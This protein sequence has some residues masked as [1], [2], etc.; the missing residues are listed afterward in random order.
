MS[1]LARYLTRQLLASIGLALAVLLLLFGFFDLIDELGDLRPGTYT[2]GKAL[3]YVALHLPA[4][5]HE[6]MPIAAVIGALFAFARLADSSEFTVMRASG[7]S[8]LRLAR[9]MVVLGAGIAAAILVIGEYLTPVSERAAQQLKLRTTTSVVA[10]EFRSGLWAKDGQSFVNAQAMLPDAT[11]VNL[12]VFQFDEQFHLRRILAAER[13]VW[14]PA[15]EWRLEGV[16][17]TRLEADGI[18]IER[19]P[20]LGWRSSVN[21]ELLAALMVPPERMAL[22][23]LNTYVA[24]LRENKQKTARFEIARWNK[25][26]HPLAAPVML[27]LALPFAYA[28]PRA[29]G[30]GARI[31]AGIL[32]GLAFYLSNRLAAHVGLLYDWP[33]ALSAILP[34]TAF[35]AAA[36]ASLWYAERR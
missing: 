35:G 10:Q 6:L 27:L 5:L 19:L 18:A 28:Q 11:L 15:G 12:K 8:P 16:T 7:L 24:H 25:L 2:L 17:L 22:G 20:A 3:L 1:I 9:Y 26:S 36:A 4:R 32:I 33:P 30:I 34:L 31:M 29:G 13:G 21:P 14:A 23:A